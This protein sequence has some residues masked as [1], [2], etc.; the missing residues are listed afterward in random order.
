M[1]GAVYKF[2]NAYV[3]YASGSLGI[4][5]DTI[6]YT[7]VID[8]DFWKCSGSMNKNNALYGE[9]V[10]DY[11]VLVPDKGPDLVLKLNDDQKILMDTL[12]D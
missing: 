9:V 8:A 7:T 2:Q 3:Q 5:D 12:I 10:F 4:I 11:E 6:H 1:N